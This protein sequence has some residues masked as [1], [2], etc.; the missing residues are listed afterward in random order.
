[1]F[2][3]QWSIDKAHIV[4]F[5]QKDR[6]NSHLLSSRWNSEVLQCERCRFALW[7]S[8]IG[9]DSSVS[10]FS[11]IFWAIQFNDEIEI[12]R[13]DLSGTNIYIYYIC[14]CNNAVLPF[15]HVQ[16][17][18]LSFFPLSSYRNNVSHYFCRSKLNH[19]KLETFW[20]C[21]FHWNLNW[22]FFL[23]RFFLC[24]CV[25]VCTIWYNAKILSTIYAQKWMANFHTQWFHIIH[26]WL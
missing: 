12:V 16:A 6:A 1:M 18:S 15:F 3:K 14:G 19:S 25:N 11:I 2:T 7:Y 20:G 26:S 21:G 23:G 9:L 17:S 4:W 5:I 8:H 10:Q 13:N 24:S 22:H